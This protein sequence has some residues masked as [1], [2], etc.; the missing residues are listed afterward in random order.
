MHI[1]DGILSTEL[2]VAA[3]VVSL[4]ALYALGRRTDPDEIPRMGFMGAALFVASLLHFPVA[5]TSIHLGLFGLAGIVIGWR[6]FPV[7]LVAL[8]FQSLLFQHGGLVSLGINSANMGAGAV[9]AWLIWRSDGLPSAV[10]AFAAGFMGI[11]TPA[12]LM[13]VEFQLS[14]Y[15]RGFFYIISLYSFAAL[16]EGALTL[17]VVSFFQKVEPR[18]LEGIKT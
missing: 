16:I 4:G 10:R 8:L 14:G 2:C 9:A 17:T 13:A 6:A 12:L 11:L 15:G 18:L 7:V 1:A 3:D 5:G